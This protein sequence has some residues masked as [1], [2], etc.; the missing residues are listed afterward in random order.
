MLHFH[1]CGRKMIKKKKSL[2]K[3]SSSPRGQIRS[4]E[5]FQQATVDACWV[6]VVMGSEEKEELEEVVVVVRGLG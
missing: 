2:T 5:L 6:S 4:N 1:L 3:A